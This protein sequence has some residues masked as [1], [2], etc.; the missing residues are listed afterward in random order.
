VAFPKKTFQAVF[1]LVPKFVAH[2]V[3]VHLSGI[4]TD[5]GGTLNPVLQFSKSYPN[6]RLVVDGGTGLTV[7]ADNG[8]SPW[9]A[10]IHSATSIG[11]AG[12]GWTLDQHAGYMVEVLT[13]PC[14]GQNRMV[15][16]NTTTTI[17]P[18]TNFTGDPGAAQFRISRPTTTLAGSS[19]IDAVGVGGGQIILQ[20]LYVTGTSYIIFQQSSCLNFV[21]HVVSDSAY[22]ASITGGA[23]ISIATDYYRYNGNTF[24]H[25]AS[26]TYSVAE[27]SVRNPLSSVVVGQCN[28]A[29]IRG[30]FTNYMA[31]R[32]SSSQLGE[33]MRAL[34][35]SLTDV[36]FTIFG[37]ANCATNRFGDP[38]VDSGIVLINCHGTIS[39]V[40]VSSCLSHG[41]NMTKSFLQILTVITGTGNVGAGIYL[42]D[43]STI[44]TKS[45]A[46]PTLTGGIGD[47]S[48]DGLVQAATWASLSG[49]D[50]VDLHQ[51]VLAKEIP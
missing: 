14:A 3:C 28:R 18:C 39:N 31:L 30:Y 23:C 24:A 41:I 48:T 21:S 34:K 5:D 47:L 35:I 8:G 42:H 38:S 15:Q 46:V 13:G 19:W 11:K 51:L 33:G 6:L 16:G 2:H 43:N 1:D 40:D 9:T 32:I 4:F 7:V 20:N 36:N 50:Y 49:G 44:Q 45:G 10:D 27:M 26:D 37:A 17:T 22:Y 12:L 29:D 25:E